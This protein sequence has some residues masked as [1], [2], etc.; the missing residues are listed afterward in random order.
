MTPTDHGAMP[1][2]PV[3]AWMTDDGRV[4]SDETKQCM[5][6]ASKV[7]FNEPLVKL[8][9]ARAAIQQAAGAV[10]EVPFAWYSAKVDDVITDAKK[11]GR[12]LVQPWD[13][14]HYDKPLYAASTA[15]PKQQPVHL[16]GGEGGGV[17]VPLTD[18]RLWELRREAKEDPR[19]VDQHWFI[20]FARRVLAEGN[21]PHWA[22][23]EAYNRSMR[24]FFNA[25]GSPLPEPADIK[26]TIGEIPIVATQ[27]AAPTGYHDPARIAAWNAANPDSAAA[28]QGMEGGDHGA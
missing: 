5:P 4:S 18:E 17:Q 13:A 24:G 22:E 15:P 9:D 7:N 28:G 25:D 2:L 16:V 26:R 21:D 12:L 10:P 8:S 6:R 23:R 11:Q 1:E 3:V 14:K 19:C 20:L 27:P